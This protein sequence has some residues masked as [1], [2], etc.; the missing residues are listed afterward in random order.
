MST[1]LPTSQKALYLPAIHQPFVVKTIPVKQPSAGQVLIRNEAVAL[2]PIDWK[3]QAAVVKREVSEFPRILGF[4]GAGIVIGVGEGVTNVKVG[5]NVLYEGNAGGPEGGT[6][7]AAFQQ[8][9]IIPAP[10]VGKI[11]SN[12]TFDQAATLPVGLTTAA[13]GL[14][15]DRIQLGGA[16]LLAPWLDGGRGKYAKYANQPILIIGAAASIVQ[17]AVMLAKLSGFSPIIT[18]SS[19]HNFA[20][21]KSLGADYTLD[22]NENLDGIEAYSKLPLNIIYDAV[23]S[24]ETQTAA[25]RVLSPGGT[26][27]SALPN[28]ISEAEKDVSK[29]FVFP[30]GSVHFPNHAEFSTKLYQSLYGLLESG[31]IKPNNVEYAPGGLNAI[32]AQLQRLKRGEVGGKKIVVR[33]S[34]TV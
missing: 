2:N 6:Q 10:F 3:V 20:H 33:P 25:Q 24:A 32:D 15:Q 13:V 9:T 34:E 11:P 19:P 26:L 30:Y 17:S 5:E 4:D 28:S 21:L 16:G 23:G 12:I 27:V 29:H 31:D 8:Y 14:Y 7:H 1:G 18:T 22:R